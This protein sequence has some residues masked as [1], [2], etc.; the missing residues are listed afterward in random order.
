MDKNKSVSVQNDKGSMVDEDVK[1]E[2]G[3]EN[4]GTGEGAENGDDQEPS[5]K[6]LTAVYPVLY[7]SRQYSVGEELPTNDPE[8]V[9]AWVAAG[10]AVWMPD[11]DPAARAKPRTAEPGI[12]GQAEY[13]EAEDRD[14]LAGKI[15]KTRA[16][17]R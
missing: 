8:I 7:L 5:P 9:E 10:T 11:M 3:G 4:Q 17:K 6:I 14:D 2:T 12:P 13:S 1:N 15:P 16:R